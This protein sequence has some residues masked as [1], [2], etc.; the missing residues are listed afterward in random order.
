MTEMKSPS[1][2]PEFSVGEIAQLVKRTVETNFERVRVRGEISGLSRPASGHVYFKLKDSDAVLDGVAWKFSAAKLGLV[3]EDGLEVIAVGK[4]TTYPAGSRYQIV[5]DRM[6]LA[7]A[8]ALLKLLEERKK[9][10]ATEGL[11][12]TERKK[13]LPFMPR[14]I[15]I[16]T[17]P[18]GAVIRD[19]LHRLA[20][21]F[22]LH[23]LLWP[24]PVQGQGA[25]AQIAA[26]ISG[27]QNFPTAGLPRPD[28][29]IV[30]RGGGSIE[31]LWE[32]N[33]EALV[34]EVAASA[35]PIISA[36][37][38]ETDFTLIDFAADLRAPTP[39]AA[40]ELATPVLA[41]LLT[42]LTERG[43]RLQGAIRQNIRT[44]Q[45]ILSVAAR[46][47]LHPKYF[48]AL[49]EQKLDDFS[50]QLTQTMRQYLL[51]RRHKL[52]RIKLQP[53]L[54]AR[55]LQTKRERTRQLSARLAQ[56]GQR[57]LQKR[58]ENLQRWQGLLQ[59][60]SYKRTLDRGYALILDAGQKPLTSAKQLHPGDAVTLRL[61]DG[62][63]A[64]KID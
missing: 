63:R 50:G 9:K 13:P 32:F 20:D 31:D 55:E 18:T 51:A 37:G 29:I 35:I 60:L 21:R 17:S 33:D 58:Q 61:R 48:L 52:Q 19:I 38:H 53:E 34:R 27:F 1:N 44:R 28:V 42:Q 11:F 41:Q 64:A 47:L 2:V 40:A 59:S 23:V 54:L 8:G 3:P 22:P 7:G 62:E 43:A 25:A 57:Q 26:A 45:Q 36:V 49:L 56:A 14:T 4:L 6:E 10:L 5:V 12:D 24:V 30:A 46:G 16:I 39:T 15:G